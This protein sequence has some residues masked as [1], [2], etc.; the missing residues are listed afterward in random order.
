MLISL[1]AAASFM[2]LKSS[3]RSL[4][5]FQGPSRHRLSLLGLV[6]SL[7]LA[8]CGSTTVTPSPA[9]LA[10]PS[11]LSRPSPSAVVTAPPGPSFATASASPTTGFVFTADDITAYYETQGYLCSASRPSTT[12]AGFSFRSCEYVDAA[13]RTHVVGV[14]TDQGGNLADGF[15]SVQGTDAETILAPTDALDP[16]AGFLGAMLG[17]EQ[18]SSLLTWLAGHLGDAYDQ[19]T[20]GTLR[21]ATYTA[22]DTDHSTLYVEVANQEYLDAPGAATP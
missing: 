14:V 11:F 8:A 16:L 19:T 4:H 18:G 10:S 6:T 12:A 20:I 3:S 7:L 5:L 13:G 22:S 2:I 9:G 17:E 21:V 1:H 15:A